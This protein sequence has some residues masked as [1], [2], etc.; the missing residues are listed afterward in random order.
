MPCAPSTAC[1]DVLR[2][3]LSG[4][5]SEATAAAYCA[6]NDGDDDGDGWENIPGDPTTWD[7]TTAGYWENGGM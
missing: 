4:R 3:S 2:T 5:V 1:S 6:P 7:P